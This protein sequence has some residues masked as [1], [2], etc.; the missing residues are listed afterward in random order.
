MSKLGSGALLIDLMYGVMTRVINTALKTG[1]LPREYISGALITHR[2]MVTMRREEML[3]SLTVVI[4]SLRI[5]VSN[6]HGAHLKYNQFLLKKF[7]RRIESHS[8]GGDV[9]VMGQLRFCKE[10]TEEQRDQTWGQTNHRA[11]A[12]DMT[13]L[14]G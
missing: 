4:I 8:H 11:E 1:N 2:K 6:H 13:C 9:G 10:R 7:K 12:T 5:C 3:T 14:I